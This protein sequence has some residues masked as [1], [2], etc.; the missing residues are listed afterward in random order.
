MPP[1]TIVSEI[2]ESGVI[3][4]V[5]TDLDMVLSAIIVL[6]MMLVAERMPVE[7]L[8]AVSLANW[9]ARVTVLLAASVRE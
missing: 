4:V 3:D 1:T 9:P 6:V 8:A 2:S 5:V 7:I